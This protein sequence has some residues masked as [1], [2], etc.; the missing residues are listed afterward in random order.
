MFLAGRTC[1]LHKV[2]PDIRD[3]TH[4]VKVRAV[5]VSVGHYMIILVMNVGHGPASL[6]ENPH[7]ISDADLPSSSGGTCNRENLLWCGH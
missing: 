5:L 3:P 2:S 4:A 6:S 7:S 1:F